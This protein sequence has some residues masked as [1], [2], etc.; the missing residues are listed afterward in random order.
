MSSSDLDIE[1]VC[2]SLEFSF[3]LAKVREMDVN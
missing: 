1:L 3:V 2:N